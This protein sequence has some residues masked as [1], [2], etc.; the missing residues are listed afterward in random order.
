[1]NGKP[2]HVHV[3]DNSSRSPGVPR[4]PG[5]TSRMSRPRLRVGLVAL[6]TASLIG[7][8]SA[9]PADA[10]GW[11]EVDGDTTVTDNPCTGQETTLVLHDVTMLIS[12]HSN[13]H[14]GIKFRGHFTTGD[15]FTG[16]FHD[17]D[18]WNASPGPDDGAFTRVVLFRGANEAKQRLTFTS[19]FHILIRDDTPAV[20]FHLGGGRCVGRP[21]QT[22]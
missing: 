13:D 20:Q 3:S 11:V 15:G 4:A 22:G 9:L 7:C 8:L 19:V 14:E 6:L 5:R 10:S 18:Q 12:G 16:T 17:L 1:M 21:Q 2:S